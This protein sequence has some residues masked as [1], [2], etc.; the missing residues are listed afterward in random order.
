MENV[1]EYKKFLSFTL[2]KNDKDNP[3][4]PTN[5][6]NPN[7][8]YKIDELSNVFRDCNSCELV[9]GIIINRDELMPILNYIIDRYKEEGDL[10]DAVY[11]LS[12]SYF[13]NLDKHHLNLI[14]KA[15]KYG[16][17]ANNIYYSAC[18][19]EDF[20]NSDQISDELIEYTI[21]SKMQKYFV[22]I[23][24]SFMYSNP[25]AYKIYSEDRDNFRL[26]HNISV[27]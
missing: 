24:Y 12:K 9:N 21:M 7:F 20:I 22:N 10:Y 19:L 23:I 2:D 27:Y 8:D 1:N 14:S 25:E 5:Y 15:I 4:K 3:I 6:T 17:H 11:P 18:K 16:K 13:K 26:L